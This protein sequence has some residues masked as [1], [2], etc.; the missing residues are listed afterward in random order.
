MCLPDL[1]K[2]LYSVFDQSS[3]STMVVVEARFNVMHTV[4]LMIQS[5]FS[6]PEQS[7]S[8]LICPQKVFHRL[9]NDYF[10]SSMEVSTIIPLVVCNNTYL[11]YS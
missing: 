5:G 7:R 11:C 3:Q 4:F 2:C 1:K 6:H 8:S 10:M 9:F